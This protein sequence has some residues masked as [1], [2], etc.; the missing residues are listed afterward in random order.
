V[1]RDTNPDTTFTRWVLDEDVAY[2]TYELI[3]APE[4]RAY[5]RSHPGFYNICIHKG[6]STT[7]PDNETSAPSGFPSDIPKAARDWPMLNFLIYHS[8]I[9]PGFWVRNALLDVQSGNMRAGGDGGP[10]VP[11]ILWTTRFLVTSAPYRNVYSELGTTFAS[12][13]IT[14]PTVCAHILGQA[15]RFFGEDRIVFGSDSVWYGAPQWQIEALWR[16]QIPEAL[17]RKYNYP[18]LTEQAKRK[19]FGLNNARLYGIKNVDGRLTD[20]SCGD[21]NHGRD[22]DHDNSHRGVYHPVPA[23]YEALIPAALKRVMEFPGFPKLTDNLSK[24]R[25]RYLASG[26]RPDHTRYG[27]VRSRS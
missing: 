15:L 14:F 16:F 9:R 20:E 27:W 12:S 23:N 21:D 26:A 18:E 8:C 25:N 22:D 2:K 10:P 4:Y 3:T 1:K 5:Q 24:I 6:L 13:V 17:R 11:D 7:A 19:I